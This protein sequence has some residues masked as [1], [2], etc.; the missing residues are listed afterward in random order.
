MIKVGRNDGI[1]V[2]KRTKFIIVIITALIIGV[3]GMALASVALPP[4]DEPLPPPPLPDRNTMSILLDLKALS[5]FFNIVILLA[6][7]AIYVGIYREVKTRFTLGLILVMV[8][9]LLYA[10]TSNPLIHILFGFQAQGLG[11]FVLIPDIFTSIALA[12]FLY[13]SLD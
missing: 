8:T 11:P 6:L 10:L 1:T 7:I 9:L 3:I 13:I 12:V 5:S 2:L 4:P